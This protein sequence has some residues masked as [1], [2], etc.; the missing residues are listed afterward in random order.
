MISTL[1]CFA[2]RAYLCLYFLLP[3]PATGILASFCP[4]HLREFAVSAI[5]RSPLGRANTFS[6][7]SLRSIPHV[8]PSVSSISPCFLAPAFPFFLSFL[9]FLPSTSQTFLRTSSLLG[10]F[11]YH[12]KFLNYT[13][14]ITPYSSSPFCYFVPHIHQLRLAAS[15]L[16]WS[17]L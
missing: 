6:L 2:T 11:Q 7:V 12:S 17:L 14:N 13:N 8:S 1:Y 3:L 9:L 15:F 10:S 5:S 4:G 16:A